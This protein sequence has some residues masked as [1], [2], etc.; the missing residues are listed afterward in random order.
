MGFPRDYLDFTTW[1]LIKKG[2]ITRAD[3]SDF[4]LTAEG[5]DFV[6]SQRVNM[7]VLN[8]MLTSGTTVSSPSPSADLEDVAVKVTEPVQA[9][10]P[11]TVTVP[12]LSM[13]NDRHTEL[14]D[15]LNTLLER[16]IVQ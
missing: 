14:A 11:R 9:A 8:R 5:V 10:A 13:H 12:D 7:P 15:H 4:T 3:N 2:Y 1:Y 6:E 16:R